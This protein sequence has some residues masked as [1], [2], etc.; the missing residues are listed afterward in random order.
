V[1]P[2]EATTL[3]TAAPM[4]VP[5]TPNAPESTAAVSAASALAIT[6]TK[7]GRPDARG[8]GGSCE[9]VV[10]G[11]AG[12]GAAGAGGTGTA[13]MRGDVSGAEDIL[14]DIAGVV[15]PARRHMGT[16]AQRPGLGAALTA[17]SL[18]GDPVLSE[19]LQDP[20]CRHR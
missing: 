2:T 5:V 11:G 16:A 13:F 8:A 1:E 18:D 7:L 12:F 17:G 9:A 14:V 10:C 4:K 6:W 19:L 15:P 3:A 20:P